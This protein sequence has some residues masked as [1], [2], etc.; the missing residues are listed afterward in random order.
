MNDILVNF[1][2]YIYLR[3]RCFNIVYIYILNTCIFL[4][5]NGF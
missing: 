2:Y 5:I 4:K 3:L 1:I